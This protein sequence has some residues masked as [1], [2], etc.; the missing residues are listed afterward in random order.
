MHQ[1]RY[2]FWQ[3]LSSTSAG[4]WGQMSDPYSTSDYFDP[5]VEEAG[6]RIE[7]Q[8]QETAV[9]VRKGRGKGGFEQDSEHV[10]GV[11]WE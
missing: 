4:N 3:E 1:R 9:G 11:L 8:G 10:G 6:A 2:K 5:A 7:S